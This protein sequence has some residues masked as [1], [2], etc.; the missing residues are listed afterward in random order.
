MTFC[1]P[2]IFVIAFNEIHNHHSRVTFLSLFVGA[3]ALSCTQ[4]YVR[5]LKC[6]M[7]WIMGE[8]SNQFATDGQKRRTEPAFEVASFVA[9]SPAAVGLQPVC[10]KFYR[11]SRSYKFDTVF[12][13]F[14]QFERILQS[15]DK[16]CGGIFISKPSAQTPTCL[17]WVGRQRDPPVRATAQKQS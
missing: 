3:S 2:L 5:P 6:G 7:L 16:P 17:K 15:K 12:I 11:S 4:G 9:E 13:F 14:C 1:F 8:Q 10:F